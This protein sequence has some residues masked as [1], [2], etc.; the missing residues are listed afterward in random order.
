MRF[1]VGFIDDESANVRT[2]QRKTSSTDIKITPL[3]LKENIEEIIEQIIESKVQCILVDYKLN[4]TKPEIR[5]NG[6]DIVNELDKNIISFPSFILTGFED[7]AE[8]ELIDIN[9]IYKK[10]D[11]FKKPEKLNRR[12][13][14]QIENYSE[15]L[16]IAEEELLS[17]KKKN[18]LSSKEEERLLELD[19]FLEKSINAK[20]SISKEIKRTSNIDRLDSLL[21][22]TRRI[23]EE[24]KKYDN[25]KSSN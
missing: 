18:S 6:A 22:K 25:E 4:L 2:V 24:V 1:N 23:L 7:D 20:G 11:Y 14:K 21:D 10:E 12:I 13:V 5:F 17:L 8:N 16:R 3:N 15:R 9:K 19:S